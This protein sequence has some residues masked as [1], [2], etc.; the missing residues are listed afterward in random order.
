MLLVP[1]HFVGC[2]MQCFLPETFQSSVVCK[3]DMLFLH[4]DGLKQTE[5][6]QS[7]DCKT[8]AGLPDGVRALVASTPKVTWYLNYASVME[9]KPALSSGSRVSDGK[10]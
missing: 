1:E 9:F 6:Q 4:P 7:V 3:P 5:D 8:C 10:T 2:H